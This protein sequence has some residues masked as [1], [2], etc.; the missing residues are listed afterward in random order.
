MREWP[1]I[2][3]EN[4]LYT[5]TDDSYKLLATFH[6]FFVSTLNYTSVTEQTSIVRTWRSLPYKIWRFRRPISSK[7]SVLRIRWVLRVDPN[8]FVD[9]WQWQLPSY[10][11]KI[12]Q[13]QKYRQTNIVRHWSARCIYVCVVYTNASALFS[14]IKKFRIFVVIVEDYQRLLIFIMPW[15]QFN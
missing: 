10:G 1:Q 7:N 15:D 4:V 11:A 14:A 13:T 12:C 9:K 5:Y 6:T 3:S 8:C 2:C